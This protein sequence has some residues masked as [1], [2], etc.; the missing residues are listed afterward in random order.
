[1]APKWRSK[2]S[3]NAVGSLSERAR[4]SASD[5]TGSITLTV[6]EAPHSL[7]GST[8]VLARNYPEGAP[9]SASHLFDAVSAE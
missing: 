1:M 8:H 4:Q 6:P 7:S 5:E 9:G 2:I 3:A